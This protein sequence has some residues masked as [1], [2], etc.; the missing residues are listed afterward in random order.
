VNFNWK[1]FYTTHKRLYNI[2]KQHNVEASLSVL[3]CSLPY[4]LQP[5]GSYAHENPKMPFLDWSNSFDD[6]GP[7][8][9]E[10]FMGSS[11]IFK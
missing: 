11:K 5:S 1:T 10:H 4:L 9:W 3:E 2:R 7:E 8:Y 6:L